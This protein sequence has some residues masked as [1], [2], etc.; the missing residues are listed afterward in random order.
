MHQITG[1][2]GPA[3]LQDLE[4]EQCDSIETTPGEVER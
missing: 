4:G 2:K 1:G 3:V